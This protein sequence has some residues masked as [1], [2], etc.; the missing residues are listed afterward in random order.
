MSCF[1]NLILALSMSLAVLGTVS[2]ANAPSTPLEQAYYAQAEAMKE[3]LEL[4][5]EQNARVLALLEARLDHERHLRKQMRTTYTPAQQVRARQQWLQRAGRSLTEAE[6]QELRRSL[7]VSD[8]Q[9]R[10]F[11]A[12]RAKLQAHREQTLI[13]VSQHLAPAQQKLLADVTFTL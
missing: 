3:K 13:L 5:P 2:L 11:E 8:A 9:E 7:G 12:Y 4:D 1:R 6:R 10:Q